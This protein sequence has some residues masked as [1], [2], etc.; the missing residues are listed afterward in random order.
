MVGFAPKLDF[1]AEA[2]IPRIEMTGSL[3]GLRDPANKLLPQDSSRCKRKFLEGGIGFWA[4][5]WGEQDRSRSVFLT[6]IWLCERSVWVGCRGGVFAVSPQAL[7]AP[8]SVC[9]SLSFWRLANYRA[10][11]LNGLGFPGPIV[12]AEGVQSAYSRSKKDVTRQR[13]M[14][15]VDMIH[16]I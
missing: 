5:S 15:Y 16:G 10:A 13:I 14:R 12:S 7:S 9:Q 4:S 11:L 2:A 1:S 6:G 3:Q 8:P